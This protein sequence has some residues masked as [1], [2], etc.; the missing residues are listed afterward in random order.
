VVTAS[1]PP[2][3]EELAME[4]HIALQDNALE[5]ADS[6]GFSGKITNH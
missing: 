1:A 4:T 6:I 5:S 2:V 3:S